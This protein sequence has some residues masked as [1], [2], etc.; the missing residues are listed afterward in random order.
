[1]ALILSWLLLD[2][3]KGSEIKS[4]NPKRCGLRIQIKGQRIHKPDGV[5]QISQVEES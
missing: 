2:D 1:M 4:L 3:G 5:S